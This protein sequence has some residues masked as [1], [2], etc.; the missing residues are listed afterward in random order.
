[1][2]EREAVLAELRELHRVVDAGWAHLAA[3][4]GERLRCRRGCADCCVDGITV[5]SVE[6]ERIRREF[7]RV[8]DGAPA[9]PGRCAFLAPDGSCRVYAARPYV[10]RTQGLPLRWIEEDMDLQLVE[11]R[12]IC[13]LNEGGPSLEDL[14]VE[15]CWEIGPTE[16]RLREL[17]ERFTGGRPRRIALR[18]LF[19][20]RE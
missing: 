8:I 2:P 13:P 1:M 3:R 18:E 20:R 15:D 6:A 14:P 17:E 10:C 4:H 19:V 9:P 5:F 7:P 16:E 11:M 12:D